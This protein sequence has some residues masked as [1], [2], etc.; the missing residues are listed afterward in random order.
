MEMYDEYEAELTDSEEERLSAYEATRVNKRKNFLNIE[1]DMSNFGEG[2]VD[3]VADKLRKDLYDQIIAKIRNEIVDDIRSNIVNG[4]GEIIKDIIL[5]FM[6]N[7]KIKIGGSYWNDTP[8]EEITLKQYAKRC[9]REAIE[10]KTFEVVTDV[11]ESSSSYGPKFNVTTKKF[12]FDE[13]LKSKLTIGNE[14]QR[15][16]DEQIAEIKKQVNKDMKNMF[17]KSTKEM[18][19]KEVLQVLMANETYQKIG[20]QVAQ[21]ADRVVD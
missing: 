6:E 11:K 1:V 8:A 2:I 20:R 3:A 19:A 12:G 15:F 21:I 5:D 13:Y 16:F 4:V 7:D 17:D 18:L 9:I 10:N 14:M